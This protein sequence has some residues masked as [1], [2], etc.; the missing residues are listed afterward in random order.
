MITSVPSSNN[1]KEEQNK[2]SPLQTLLHSSKPTR[3]RPQSNKSGKKE[4][5]NKTQLQTSSHSLIPTAC[6][7]QS[8]KSERNT[9]RNK[10]INK[11]N[12]V[13]TPSCSNIN[14][15]SEHMDTSTNVVNLDKDCH[16]PMDISSNNLPISMTENETHKIKSE[17]GTGRG[18]Y[19]YCF[20]IKY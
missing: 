15:N 6:R 14:H 11:D 1:K 18:F 16:I 10:S 4:V 5:Q 20:Y 8:N 9:N 2:T 3:Y 7:S 19:K 12:I 13:S 17:K